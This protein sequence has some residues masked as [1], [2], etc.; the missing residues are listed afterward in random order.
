M[1]LNNDFGEQTDAEIMRSGMRNGLRLWIQ[2]VEPLIMLIFVATKPENNYQ[3]P[4]GDPE[5][6]RNNLNLL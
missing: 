6:I 1:F 4:Q 5:R 2:R 3:K